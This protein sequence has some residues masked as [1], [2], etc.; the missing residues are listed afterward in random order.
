MIFD[1]AIIG[2]GVVGAA[3]ARRLSSYKLSVALLEQRADVSFG[4]SKANSGII[5]AGFHHNPSMLKARLEIQGSLLFDRLKEELGFPFR[6]VGILVAAFSVE[7]LK[8]VQA[9]YE[10]GVANGVPQ[11]EIVGRERILSLEP[12]LS[13][14]TVGGLWAPTGGIIEPYR[15]VFALMENAQANGLKLFTG[16]KVTA[17]RR[18]VEGWQLVS[19]QGQTLD[20]RRV[21]NAAGL[22]ADEVSACFGAEEFR[23]IPRK[24]EEFLLDR[25]AP[26]FPSHVIFP[27]PARNSKGVLVIPTVEGTMMVG[28]TAVEI[29]EKEDTG[30]T[31]ENLDRVFSQA[32]RMVPAISKR[33]IITSFAGLR[34]TLP[35]ED[36]FI[37]ISKKA[38]GLVQAAG[39]QSPGLTAAPAIAEYVKDLLRRDGLELAEKP[40]FIPTIRHSPKVIEMSFPEMDE[41][42][43]RVPAYAHIVC[44]CESVS[45]AEVVEA[46]RRGHTTLDGVKFYTRA[47]M[48]RCQGGFCTYRILSIIARETGMPVDAI[49]KR[50]KGSPIV[51]GRIGEAPQGSERGESRMAPRRNG[52]G[53]SNA[54]GAA[55]ETF[56]EWKP[57]RSAD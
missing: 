23:I 47:G 36:F 37:D 55:G 4:V 7:D 1:V 46:I 14:D 3:I 44:R 16:W 39:I 45:E 10:M 49:T 34:P 53:G 2:A 8:T 35:G 6:R 56:S 17:A 38:P 9:L 11:L 28:P 30:T 26:G 48:G 33:D 43:Q 19:E 12:K 52:T 40:D 24:G 25:N 42:V 51:L 31:P 54:G 15:F 13:G 22:Y 29:D 32:A 27:V 18:A 57:S 5:H 20:A 21:V 41:L 50:G